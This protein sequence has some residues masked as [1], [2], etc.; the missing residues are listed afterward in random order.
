M[1]R[2][3]ALLFCSLLATGLLATLVTASAEDLAPVALNSLPAAPS[4]IV[5]LKVMDQNGRVIGQALRVRTDRNGHPSALAFRAQDG[6][7]VEIPASAASYDGHALVTS[8]DQPQ[9]AALS[10]VQTAKK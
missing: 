1:S 7:T 8:N 4:N 2:L 6:S 3:R 9:I 5:A 10:G